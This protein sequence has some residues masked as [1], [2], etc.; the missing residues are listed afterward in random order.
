MVEVPL[1]PIVTPAPAQA[2]Q[3]NTPEVLNVT[4]SAFAADAVSASSPATSAAMSELLKRFFFDISLF[5]LLLKPTW[6]CWMTPLCLL[7][8]ARCLRLLGPK[9]VGT[10]TIRLFPR[11]SK[12]EADLR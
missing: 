3:L 4:L 1:P 6:A 8:T 12:I 9:V 10:K 11:E 5:P 7:N 2:T